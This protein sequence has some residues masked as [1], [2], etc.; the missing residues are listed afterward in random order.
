[1]KVVRRTSR[2]RSPAEFHLTYLLWVVIDDL[3]QRWEGQRLRA[4]KNR[5]RKGLN[6]RRKSYWQLQQMLFERKLMK[7]FHQWWDVRQNKS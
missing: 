6:A 4:K 1:M 7:R 3:A 2:D 5:Q